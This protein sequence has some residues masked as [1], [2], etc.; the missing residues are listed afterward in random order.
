MVQQYDD[1]QY[2]YLVVVHVHFIKATNFPILY[3]EQ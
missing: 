2:E 3:N 1:S